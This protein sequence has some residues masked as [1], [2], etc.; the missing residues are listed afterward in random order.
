MQN[1]GFVSRRGPPMRSMQRARRLNTASRQVRIAAGLP[2]RLTLD[3]SVPG[4]AIWRD[5][6]AVGDFGQAP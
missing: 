2:G 3:G 5:R 6:I 4:P 1:L